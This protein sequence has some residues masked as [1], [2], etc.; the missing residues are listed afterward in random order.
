MNVV[1]QRLL[2]TSVTHVNQVS[3]IFHLVKKVFYKLMMFIGR[4]NFSFQNVS[5]IPKGQQLWNVET[6]M[7][8]A[9]A[10][11]DSLA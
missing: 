3:L 6:S 10:K 8:I 2:V 11:R 4:S 1:C 7:V 9:L 5:V